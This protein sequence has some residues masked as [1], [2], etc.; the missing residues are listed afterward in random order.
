MDESFNE[1]QSESSSNSSPGPTVS[2][3]DDLDSTR[4][5]DSRDSRTNCSTVMNQEI[6]V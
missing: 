3:V 5:C 2:N 6:S 4:G 1:L